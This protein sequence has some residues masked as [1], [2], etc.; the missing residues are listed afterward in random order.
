MISYRSSVQS[1]SF[2]PDNKMLVSGGFRDELLIW[3]L[4]DQKII[5]GYESP[6]KSGGMVLDANW[7]NDGLMI[8]AGNNKSIVLFDIRY[9]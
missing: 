1:L 4:Q 9:I 7:S 5:K 8:A 2:S 6:N 3:S